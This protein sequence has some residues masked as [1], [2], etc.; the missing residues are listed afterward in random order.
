MNDIV[1]TGLI[2]FCTSAL[3]SVVTWMLA[4]RKYNAE[5]DNHLIENMKES[6]DFY[7]QLSDDNKN[8]LEEVL[9]RNEQLEI[10]DA[11]LEEEVRE[12][13]AQL[14]SIMQNICYNLTCQIRQKEGV[15]KHKKVD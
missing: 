4:K 9:K 3:T 5:V 6:L 12:L 10:R 13:R 2:T 11:K 8:R 15:I 7:R 1:L 14:F